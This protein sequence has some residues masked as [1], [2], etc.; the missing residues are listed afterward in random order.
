MVKVLESESRRFERAEKDCAIERF[1]KM[2]A[3]VFHQE[4]YDRVATA[5]LPEM[6]TTE[7]DP[8]TTSALV[9]DVPRAGEALVTRLGP[10][11]R[12]WRSTATR[13]T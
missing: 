9:F 1:F 7:G 13:V 3:P 10:L 11:R 5:P 12:A 6:R 8:L 2:V 4:W